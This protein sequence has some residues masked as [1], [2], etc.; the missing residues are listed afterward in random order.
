M[1]ICATSFRKEAYVTNTPRGAPLP[2]VRGRATSRI[3]PRWGRAHKQGLGEAVEAGYC[4]YDG[5][6][7]TAIGM[8]PPV[9][10]T[11]TRATVKPIIRLPSAAD[12]CLYASDSVKYCV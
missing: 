8:H 2:L 10:P 7:T 11:S 6:A 5:N 4:N 3:Y 9:P 12:N 1:P